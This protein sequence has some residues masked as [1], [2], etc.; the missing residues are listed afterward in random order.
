MADRHLKFYDKKGHPLN[1]EYV[2][3]EPTTPLTLTFNYET[4]SN[5]STPSAGKISFFNLSSNLIYINTVDANGLDITTWA[6]SVSESLIQ[7]AKITL[8]L[9]VIP[10]IVI[11]AE[12]F[13]ASV[14][15]GVITLNLIRF[16][17]TSSVSNG[18]MV[19]CETICTDL[20]GGYF[21]GNIYF[22]PVSAGLY[23][24]EQIF[25]IQQ[26]KDAVTGSPFIGFP[27]T[28]NTGATGN[29][30]WR[31]RWE[32]DT[33]GNVDVSNIIFTYKIIELHHRGLCN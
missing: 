17:G 23:E 9:N 12:I 25:I 18:N 2:G 15:S 13:S 27:H 19:Y 14:S 26:F 29:P 3:S 6:N 31:T 24:N 4:A 30:L 21:R 33:Y 10:G 28:G 7:G 1:F 16:V 20:P 8:K 11:L 32:D 5:N 22:E